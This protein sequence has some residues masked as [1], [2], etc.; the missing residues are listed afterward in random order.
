MATLEEQV[1]MAELMARRAHSGQKRKMGP[2][3]DQAYIV[4]PERIAKK[5]QV[6]KS[7]YVMKMEAIAWLHDVVE[8]TDVTMD[9][10]RE[11]FDDQDII[12]GVECMTQREGEHYAAYI[13]RVSYNPYAVSVKIEDLIDNMVGLHKGSMRD[14]YCMALMFLNESKKWQDVPRFKQIEEDWG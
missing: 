13:S 11:A 5:F 14:K 4:H 1:E 3:K 6:C 2:D 10:I 7:P 12:N 8:D 9:D